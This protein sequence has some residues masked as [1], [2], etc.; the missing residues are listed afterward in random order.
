VKIRKELKIGI[1]TT[2]AIGCFIYGF[3]FL[4][5]K[6]LFSSQREFYAVYTDIDGLVEAN[7]ILINGNRVGMV[8]KIKFM[9]NTKGQVVV[10]L[11]IQDDIP[12]PF[13]SVAK[14]VS[15]DILGSKAV[16]ILLGSSPSP[17]K[18]NDTLIAAQEDNLKQAVN[19]TIAPLQLKAQSLLASIDS[20]MIVFKQVFNENTQKNLSKSFESIKDAIGSLEVTSFR[21]DTMVRTEKGKISIILTKINKIAT[22]LSDNSDKLGNVINNFSNISD[23]IAKSKLISAINNADITLKQTSTIFTKIN[24]GEGTMGMLVNNDSLYKRLDKTADDLDKLIIEL[25]ENP[26][27][28]LAPLG[29]KKRSKKTTK[30]P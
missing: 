15:S 23:S 11:I 9:P 13:N 22:T 21:L 1:I 6:N 12:I 24:N 14:V 16:S 4:K 27:H 18:T 29:K 7:P 20:L 19:K 10:S 5:G 17:A 2:I 25:N 28:F 26:N 30:K 3:N 8:G